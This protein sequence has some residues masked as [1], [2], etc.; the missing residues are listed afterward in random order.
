M[1]LIYLKTWIFLL[2]VTKKILDTIPRGIK[3]R[4]KILS[5]LIKFIDLY[6][7]IYHP[8][9][10][11][12]NLLT[13][14]EEVHKRLIYMKIFYGE[15]Y[16]DY[17]RFRRKKLIFQDRTEQERLFS[18]LKFIDDFLHDKEVETEKFWR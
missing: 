7:N 5:L 4:R 18:E 16:F 2:Q 12:I 15:E 6:F 17:A 9:D 13:L 8:Y 3:L 11:N 1:R 10:K 14:R